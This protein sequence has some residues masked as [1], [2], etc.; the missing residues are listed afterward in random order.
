NLDINLKKLGIELDAEKKKILL[1]KIVELGDKKESITLE[2]L[3]YLISDIFE[4]RDKLPFKLVNC[5]VNT[6]YQF[7]P[8]SAVKCSYN[9]KT[10]EAY[11]YGDGGYDA[12]MNSLKQILQTFGIEI[13]KLSDYIVTIPPGGKTDA[14]VQ[15]TIYWEPRDKE[16]RKTIVTKGINSDQIMA[17]IEATI[18]M[19]NIILTMKTDNNSHQ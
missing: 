11:S 9:G 8:F 10:M 17:A 1:N 19:V 6:T 12:F 4:V 18:R 13:P 14:L 2:D 15:T 5:V 7:K 3:P 16:S